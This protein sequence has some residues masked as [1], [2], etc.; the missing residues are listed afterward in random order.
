[1][2]E[3]YSFFFFLILEKFELAFG[4]ITWTIKGNI[5]VI[6]TTLNIWVHVSFPIYSLSQ[7]KDLDYKA[8][9]YK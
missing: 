2:Y 1:M 7:A 8:N 3:I 5:Q 4:Q 9:M 6:Q